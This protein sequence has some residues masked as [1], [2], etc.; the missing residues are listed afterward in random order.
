MLVEGWRVGVYSSRMA[1]DELEAIRA[2]RL[3]ELQ[4]Q[5]GS[6]V[7]SL[8]GSYREKFPF[9]CTETETRRSGETGGGPAK[10]GRDEELDSHTNLGAGCTCQT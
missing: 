2:K 1:D 8:F 9:V 10:G 7:L 3:A 4:A 5:Y 6:Q